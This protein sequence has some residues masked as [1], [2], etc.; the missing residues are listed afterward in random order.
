[1]FCY[2]NVAYIELQMGSFVCAVC[3]F[4][5]R[6]TT[7]HIV[8]LTICNYSKPHECYLYIVKL[9]MYSIFNYIHAIYT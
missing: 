8:K 1:M 5:L 2:K 7:K 3:A 9:T 6:K 4:C